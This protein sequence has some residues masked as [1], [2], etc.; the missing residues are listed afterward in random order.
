[1]ARESLSVPE[2]HL[3]SVVEVIRV[4]L[5]HTSVAQEIRESLTAWCDDEEAYLRGED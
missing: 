2:E 3:E 4:G 1:M 5:A